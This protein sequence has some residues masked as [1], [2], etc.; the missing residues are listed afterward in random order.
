MTIRSRFVC[1]EINS[2]T[3]AEALI[4]CHVEIAQ[5]VFV[6]LVVRELPKASG[7]DSER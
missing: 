7:S 4:A 5:L 2:G 3:S 1:Q 6:V